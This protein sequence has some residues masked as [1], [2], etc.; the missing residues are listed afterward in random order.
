MELGKKEARLFPQGVDD[1]GQPLQPEEQP[2]ALG[3]EAASPG[4]RITRTTIIARA[5][6]WLHPPVRYRWGAYK[7]GYRMD[8]SGYVSMAW[9]TNVNYW[10]GNLHTIAWQLQSYNDLQA[11]DMLLYHNK[12]NPSRGS[13]VV[14]FHTWAGAIGGDFYI[15]ELSPAYAK[16][17]L[18]SKTRYSRS[19]YKPFTYVN[20]WR[21]PFE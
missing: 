19:R 6:S 20:V 7:N 17:R 11:G 16:R 21:P 3:V 8:C 13:H 18:W 5:D 15:Y 10:T 9:H 4:P 1:T 2:A 14:L 12:A